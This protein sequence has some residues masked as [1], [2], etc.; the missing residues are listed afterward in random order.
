M[1]TTV[2]VRVELP[3]LQNS[4]AIRLCAKNGPFESGILKETFTEWS[5]VVFVFFDASQKNILLLILFMGLMFTRN[6]VMGI[7]VVMVEIDTKKLQN[8][9]SL[10]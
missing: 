7:L 9:G 5:R 3:V 1:R 4:G 2:S 10:L 6:V 8:E